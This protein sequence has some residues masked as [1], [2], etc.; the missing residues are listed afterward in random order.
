MVTIK[1][2]LAGPSIPGVRTHGEDSPPPG[3]TGQVVG[4]NS[5]DSRPFGVA[6]SLRCCGA[7]AG[8]LCTEHLV[9][10]LT[11]AAGQGCGAG[12]RALRAGRRPLRRVAV[13]RVGTGSSR[14]T[15]LFCLIGDPVSSASWLSYPPSFSGYSWG[16]PPDLPTTPD[17][18]PPAR[19]R[20]QPVRERL[21]DKIVHLQKLQNYFDKGEKD[22]PG[23]L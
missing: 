16:S 8:V 5:R 13:A 22:F 20:K 23:T 19:C 15:R 2:A 4:P 11:S 18:G 1:S 21:R 10:M 7:V 9:A 6:A 12:L 14:L 3:T 17:Y